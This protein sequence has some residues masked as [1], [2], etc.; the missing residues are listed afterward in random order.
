MNWDGHQDIV[1]M[2]VDMLIEEHMDSNDKGEFQK[3]LNDKHLVINT[4]ENCIKETEELN[5]TGGI[6]WYAIM[7]TIEQNIEQ[8]IS[9]ARAHIELLEDD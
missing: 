4:I 6:I 1:N 9:S 8:I 7:N 2:A 3:I 5:N